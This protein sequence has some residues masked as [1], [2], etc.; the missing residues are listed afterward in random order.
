MTLQDEIKD[1]KTRIHDIMCDKNQF[2]DNRA[3][4]KFMPV[5]SKCEQIIWDK[6]D[7]KEDP[8]QIEDKESRNIFKTYSVF[9]RTCPNCGKIFESIEIPKKLPFNNHKKGGTIPPEFLQMLFK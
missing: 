4:I 8:N 3:T 7:F 6:I 1:L 9:P 2:E 5:C